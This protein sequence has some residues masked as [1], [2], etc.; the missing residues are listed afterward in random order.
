MG[1]FARLF[2][3]GKAQ[4]SPEPAR[5]L[6]A[7]KGAICP[8]CERQM[9]PGVPCPFCN[10]QQFGDELEEGTVSSNYKPEGSVKEGLA[11]VI[12]AD[13]AAQ[14]HG[15]KGFL[16]VFQGANKGATVLLGG[17]VVSIGRGT[18]ENVLP[19]NDSGVS[20]RHCEVRP[21][22]GG[23]QAVDV[24][25]KNGTFVND[26]RVKEKPLGNGDVIGF[27]GTRIYVGIY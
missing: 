7:K 5:G 1:I 16:H 23:F 2:G 12:V 4:P 11:G 6:P 25:S 17:K 27:G 18:G 22:D 21:V 10:P 19:L 8:S 3:G 26:A 20:T 9:L 24:G 13:Q 15:A 14:K